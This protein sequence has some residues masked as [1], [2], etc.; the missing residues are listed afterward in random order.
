MKKK[1]TQYSLS[2]KLK[3]DNKTTEEFELMLSSLTLEEIIGLKLELSSKLFGANL[4]G[5]PIFHSVK[6]LVNDALLKYAI[7]A[8]RTKREAAAMLG[9]APKDFRTYIKKYKTLSFFEDNC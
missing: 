5:L 3:K 2:N 8:S 6:E 1:I 7:S 4:Y 9:L